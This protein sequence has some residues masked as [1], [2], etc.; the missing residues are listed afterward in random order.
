MFRKY[1]RWRLKLKGLY[2]E[3]M[4]SG[5]YV[6]VLASYQ[7]NVKEYGIVKWQVEQNE[8]TVVKG[9]RKGTVNE[10]YEFK[11]SVS[12]FRDPLLPLVRRS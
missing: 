2:T 8:N 4:G 12:S 10:T 11:K 7:I 3:N 5:L 9:A 1:I 6:D